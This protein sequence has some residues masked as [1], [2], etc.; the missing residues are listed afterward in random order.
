MK[1]GKIGVFFLEALV[2]AKNLR[3]AADYYGDYSGVNAKKLLNKANKFI[4]KVKEII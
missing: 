3:E 1:E 2:E 4:E